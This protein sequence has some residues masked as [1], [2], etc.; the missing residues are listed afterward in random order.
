M[1]MDQPLADELCEAATALDDAGDVLDRLHEQLSGV[2]KS[3]LSV[4]ISSLGQTQRQLKLAVLALK[5]ETDKEELAA[6]PAQ[7]TP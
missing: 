7:K 3:H 4:A 1:E 5:A 6:A 2:P